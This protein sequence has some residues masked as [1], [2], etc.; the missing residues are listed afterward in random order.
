MSMTRLE[1]WANSLIAWMDDPEN[2]RKRSRFYKRLGATTAIA[3]MLTG[4][5]YFISVNSVEVVLIGA[6]CYWIGNRDQL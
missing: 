4:V 2:E 6:V 3:L 5:T 1:N